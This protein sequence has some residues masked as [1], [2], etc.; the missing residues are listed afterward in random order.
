M[1]VLGLIGIPSLM[2]MLTSVLLSQNMPSAGRTSLHGIA[3]DASTH[4]PLANVIVDVDSQESGNAMQAETDRS[5]KF[6]VQGLYPAVYIVR[7]RT[8]GY[9]EISERIDLTVSGNNYLSFD[10]KPDPRETKTPNSLPPGREVTVDAADTAVPEKARKEFEKGRKVFIED[11]NP[12]GSVDHFE[13]AT[14]IYPAFAKAY[15][16]LGM[17]Y[18]QLNNVAAGK[19]AL[20]KTVEINPKM[21]DAQIT[22]GSLLN[23]EK[24]YTEAEKTLL[25]GLEVKPDSPEGQYEIAKTYWA[26][27]RW[28]E[29]EPHAQKAV[30][31]KPDMPPVHV[32]LGNISLRKS[33]PE[34]ALKEFR[35]YLRLDPSGPFAAGT[36]TIVEKLSRAPAPAKQP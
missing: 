13:K 16:L 18:L 36:K 27:G 26:M 3:R 6:D 31:V 1:K 20:Q 19:A 4:A 23:Q 34:G 11:K 24:N 8:P 7:I 10:L 2:L 32:L 22:L 25:R 28:P 12:Q 35:E 5:G 30:A 14:K 15:F 9:R 33:D 29:A 17:A 21:A